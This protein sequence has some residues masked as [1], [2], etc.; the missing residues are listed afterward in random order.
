MIKI[1]TLLFDC[2]MQVGIG[3]KNEEDSSRCAMI[4]RTPEA[5]ELF[6]AEF[7]QQMDQIIAECREEI[8]LGKLKFP[9][10]EEQ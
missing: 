6:Q 7:N 1:S 9:P 4:F 8:R 10:R 2:G 3:F 5:A